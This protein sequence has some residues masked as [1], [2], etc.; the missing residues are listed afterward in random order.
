[1]PANGLELHSVWAAKDVTVQFYDNGSLIDELKDITAKYD[2]KITQPTF[3]P[4]PG[5]HLVGW[6][7]DDTYTEEFD[8]VNTAVTS[9]IIDT[10][11]EKEVVKIYGKVEQDDMTVTFVTHADNHPTYTATV[12]F[13]E[14]VEQPT[15][16]S[17]TRAGYKDPTDQNPITWNYTP[18]GGNPVAWNFNDPVNSNLT[19]DAQ[20]T[21]EKMTLVWVDRSDVL[22]TSEPTDVGAKLNPP[23]DATTLSNPGYRVDREKA[24]IDDLG[25]IY[26]GTVP[27]HEATDSKWVFKVNWIEQ[28]DVS[29]IYN[30]ELIK[31]IPVDK[32]S[33][34]A[35]NE[36]VPKPEDATKVYT[37]TLK[38]EAYDL[39]TPVTATMTLVGTLAGSSLPTVLCLKHVRSRTV[40][41]LTSLMI[42]PRKAGPS[43][44]GSL[45][46]RK[47]RLTSRLPSPKISP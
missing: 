29:F 33:K 22:R 9:D 43:T 47:P 32:N 31:T 18:S 38:G 19:L 13:G 40:R 24:W 7:T 6:Y 35:D 4:A 28:V 1:M 3:T 14:K 34:L 36:N 42:P 30:D 23:V 21:A 20:W 12:K 5:W 41:P 25:N 11:G 44:A 27:Y 10:T 17:W 2:G 8:F 37:W 39:S 26:D 45:P 15:T 46:G 16:T